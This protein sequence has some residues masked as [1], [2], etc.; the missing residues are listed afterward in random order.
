MPL[1]VLT[2]V[3]PK[4]H[5]LDGVWHLPIKRGHFAGTIPGHI[6]KYTEYPACG[7]YFQSYSVGGSSDTAFLAGLESPHEKRQFFFGGGGN[8]Q[9]YCKVYGID[10][11]GPYAQSYSVG[12]SSD[13]AFSLSPLQ[14]L[15]YSFIL[16]ESQCIAGDV[17]EYWPCCRTQVLA[18]SRVLAHLVDAVRR[19]SQCRQS[20]RCVQ[21]S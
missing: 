10:G 18:V 6:V 11:V 14:Q 20:S 17:T 8:L 15:V 13:A 1:G 19:R 9:T 16:Q 4:N 3:G 21:S 7:R 2:P 12:G 5:V